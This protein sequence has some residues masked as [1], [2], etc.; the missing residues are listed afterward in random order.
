MP[1]FRYL[2]PPY[3]RAGAPGTPWV[4]EGWGGLGPLNPNV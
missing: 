1:S 2:A 4:A 3:L